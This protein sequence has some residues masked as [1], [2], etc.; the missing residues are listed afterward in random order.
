MPYGISKKSGGDSSANTKKMDSCVLSVIKQGKSK[1]AAIRICKAGIFDEGID[2]LE[3]GDIAAVEACKKQKFSE[4]FQETI[5]KAW[6]KNIIDR[7]YEKELDAT[8]FEQILWNIHDYFMKN[9]Y[10]KAIKSLD[11]ATIDEIIDEA[12]GMKTMNWPVCGNETS[13]WSFSDVSEFK[14]VKEGDKVEIQIMRAGKWQHPIYGEI[15]VTE[16]TIN[17]VVS[18]FNNNTRWIDIAVDENHE[19]NHKALGWYKELT[20][21]GKNALNATIEL[22]KM[23]A[24]LINQGAYK[25][26]SPEIAFNKKDEETWKTIK[27]LLIGGAFTNRPFFKAMKPLMASEVGVA[28]QEVDGNRVLFFNSNSSMKTILD[29]LAKF[30]E[31]QALAKE[32]KELLKVKFSELSEDDKTEDLTNAVTEATAEV[33]EETK[34][35]SASEGEETET[36]GEEGEKSSDPE[37]EV[38]ASEG[39]NEITIKASEY[40]SLKSLA[41]QASKLIREKRKDLISSK[42]SAMAFSETNKKGVVLPKMV[43]EVVDFALSLSETQSEKFL[44]IVEKFQVVAASEIGHDGNAADVADKDVVNF[45]MEKLHM[46]EEEA[47]VAAIEAKKDIL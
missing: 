27:N 13:M 8:N 7:L 35:V 21:V 29:L 41:T 43:S 10:W 9:E 5:D 16:E 47:K 2:S 23:W 32:D 40:E 46:S 3:E 28:C 30:A 4:I 6:A 19:P 31:S 45:F 20:K 42:V 33:A 11:S 38:K 18:N 36:E 26:F 37:G 34:E 39:E 14:E 15:K 1:E 44:G 24:D 22:T 12:V 17:D 25:Y